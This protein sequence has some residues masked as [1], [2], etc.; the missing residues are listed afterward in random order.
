VERQK[1]VEE[2]ERK[3]VRETGGSQREERMGLEES[4]GRRGRG[5][6]DHEEW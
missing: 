4:L 2:C 3:G 5:L 1:S 6:V